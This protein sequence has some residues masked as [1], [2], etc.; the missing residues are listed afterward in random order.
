MEQEAARVAE[1]I[2]PEGGAMRLGQTTG[3]FGRHNQR[4]AFV[5][6]GVE[7]GSYSAVALVLMAASTKGKRTPT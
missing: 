1:R 3:G 2:C 4:G 5:S 7:D 6:F